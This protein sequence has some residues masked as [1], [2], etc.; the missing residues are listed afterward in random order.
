MTAVATP[1]PA[2]NTPVPAQI[3]K[4]PTSAF[5]F[6]AFQSN[7]SAADLVA[8]LQAYKV[9]IVE[10]PSAEGYYTVRLPDPL[11][12]DQFQQVVES[13]KSQTQLVTNVV[14]N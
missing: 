2:I 6:V 8:F 7:I 5:V 4:T 10:G 14:A 1:Q 13:M 9:S 11:P 3:A 12:S